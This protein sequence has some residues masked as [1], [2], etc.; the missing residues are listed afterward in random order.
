[1]KK[2]LLKKDESHLKIAFHSKRQK[3]I[4][5]KRERKRNN[6]KKSNNNNKYFVVFTFFIQ[7]NLYFVKEHIWENLVYIVTSVLQFLSGR[8]LKMQ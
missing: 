5:E 2:H 1:M 4:I 6:E 7:K 8:L 3:K